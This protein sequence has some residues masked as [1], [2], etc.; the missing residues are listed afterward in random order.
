MNMKRKMATYGDD[1]EG[2]DGTINSL[3]KLIQKYM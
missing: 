1:N 3:D 2:T